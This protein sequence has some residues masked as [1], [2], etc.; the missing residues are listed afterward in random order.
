M[1][2]FGDGLSTQSLAVLQTTKINKQESPCVSREGVL[3]L[4]VPVAV[5]I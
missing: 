4:T 5:L 2:H 3:Q 1:G